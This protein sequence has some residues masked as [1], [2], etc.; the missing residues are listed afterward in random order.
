M[1]LNHVFFN[2]QNSVGSADQTNNVEAASQR[3]ETLA[4]IL[5][6]RG[7]RLG[8]IAMAGLSRAPDQNNGQEC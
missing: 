4:L 6:I 7:C 5:I 2:L 8:L 1:L 3:E